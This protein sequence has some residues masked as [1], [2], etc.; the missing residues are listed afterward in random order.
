MKTLKIFLRASVCMAAIITLAASCEKGEKD[1]SVTFKAVA[2]TV[3]YDNA[4]MTVSHDGSSTDTYCGFVYDDLTTSVE[5][6]ISRKV[7]ELKA[8]GQ[9]ALT[10]ALM[11][12]TTKKHSLKNLEAE[13]AYRYVVFGLKE[14]GSTYGTYGTCDFS[15]KEIDIK[16]AATATEIASTSVKVE[17]TVSGKDNTLTWYAF[18]TSDLTSDVAALVSAEASK[19][20]ASA[21]M[22]GKQTVEF[23]GLSES[24]S[25]RVIVTGMSAAGSVY[26]APVSVNV[27][28]KEGIAVTYSSWLGSW[29]MTGANGVV[30][31]VTIEANVEGES[32]LIGGLC[33][34]EGY[35]INANYNT[36]GTMTIVTTD[37]ENYTHDSYGEIDLWFFG[38]YY[39]APADS[40]YFITGNYDLCNGTLS[41]ATSGTLAAATV[42]IQ[43]GDVTIKT[44]EYCGMIL[45]GDYAGYVLSYD[46]DIMSFPVTVVKAEG[47]S[48]KT[49]SR[50]ILP[51]SYLSSKVLRK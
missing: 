50:K 35:Y 31:N 46:A 22:T 48:A 17:V 20:T 11:T 36:D 19:V 30:N 4:I 37:L 12:G 14:D 45:T 5:N 41:D 18:C 39:Y 49:A 32:Y 3:S 2:T 38:T 6:A 27:T 34:W 23:K 24:T 33:G 21:L 28:T 44:M 10:S 43:E 15:T 25:Y 7:A 26:G 16:F 40:D 8:E 29:T 9:R 47:Q 42:A 1:K 51:V 13:K